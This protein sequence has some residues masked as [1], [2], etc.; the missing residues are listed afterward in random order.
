VVEKHEAKKRNRNA[1]QGD[2]TGAIATQGGKAP[3]VGEGKNFRHEEEGESE[4]VRGKWRGGLPK[5]VKKG[6]LS[7]ERNGNLKAAKG[8]GGKR[9]P[10]KST[11][12]SKGG[13]I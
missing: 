5:P 12:P 10:W 6:T 8:V 3:P 7:G 4:A 11:N 2:S 13:C 9:G 1:K